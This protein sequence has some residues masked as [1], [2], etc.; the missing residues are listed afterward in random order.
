MAQILEI[1]P[2]R[3]ADMNVVP[4]SVVDHAS[5][6]EIRLLRTMLGLLHID[7]LD[8]EQLLGQVEEIINF[9]GWKRKRLRQTA[10]IADAA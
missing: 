8:R 3:L 5:A 7:R 2:E 1:P 4:S 9:C 6:L 10:A